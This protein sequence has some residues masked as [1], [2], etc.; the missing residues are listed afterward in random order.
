M[1]MRPAPKPKSAWMR[2]SAAWPARCP[3]DSPR[4]RQPAHGELRSNVTRE[5][6]ME[7]VR[8]AKEH[9][10]AGDIF[11]VVLSQRL[12]RETTAAL[13]PSTARCAA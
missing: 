8:A 2:L 9:I 3:G 5:Q 13:S 6:F 7:S 4:R 12:S 10:A 1:K 11:Q